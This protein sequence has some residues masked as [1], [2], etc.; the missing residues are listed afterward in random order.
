MFIDLDGRFD[1][2][3]VL[4]KTYDGKCGGG[5]FGKFAEYLKISCPYKLIGKNMDPIH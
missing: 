5:G 2:F 1:N 3:A 4:M